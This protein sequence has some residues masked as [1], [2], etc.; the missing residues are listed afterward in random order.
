MLEGKKIAMPRYYKDKIYSETQKL[1]IN[2]HLKI[3]MSDEQIK[4]EL[5]LVQE[6]GDLAEKVL[7]E[8][9]KNSFDKMY[10]HTQL[11]RDKLEKL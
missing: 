4:Q 1:L 6:F 11:G 2:N 10:K 8:R 7:V 9:H 5:E 3:V